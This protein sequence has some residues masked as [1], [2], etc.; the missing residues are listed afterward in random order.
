LLTSILELAFCVFF[1]VFLYW[2]SQ[3]WL[4]IAV[5]LTDW[6]DPTPE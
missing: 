3:L 2:M 5:Q 6:K 4:S 1:C